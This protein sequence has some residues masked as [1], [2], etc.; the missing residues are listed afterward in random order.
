MGAS[1]LALAKSIDYA[2]IHLE[3]LVIK[4]ITLQSKMLLSYAVIFFTNS[5]YYFLLERN[6]SWLASIPLL[7]LDS[8]SLFPLMEASLWI[9][10][11]KTGWK[12]RENM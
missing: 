3:Q 12:Y 1:L 7:I 6:I 5:E 10:L 9:F 2:Q 8:Q 4:F 11:N